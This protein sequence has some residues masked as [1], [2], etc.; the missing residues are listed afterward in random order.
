[1]RSTSVVTAVPSIIQP[2]LEVKV[3]GHVHC[4]A[5]EQAEEQVCDSEAKEQC[6]Q[7]E[8]VVEVQT[9]SWRH[10]DLHLVHLRLNPPRL[11]DH[12]KDPDARG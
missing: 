3:S 1:K 4:Q 10:L 2:Q 12:S 7:E 8:S 6:E 11:M 9:P 5:G